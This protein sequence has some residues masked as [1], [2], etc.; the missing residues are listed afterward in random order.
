MNLSVDNA[1]CPSRE[2]VDEVLHLIDDSSSC[3]SL[4][5][6]F[7]STLSTASL[8]EQEDEIL[9][10]GGEDNYGDC[11]WEAT[12]EVAKNTSP[13]PPCR[14]PT[15]YSETTTPKTS[16]RRFSRAAISNSML[17]MPT[18]GSGSAFSKKNRRR[19]QS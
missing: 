6:S 13:V 16:R 7:A 2:F 15:P 12:A 18:D 14:Y 8:D 9:S 10:L 11:R 4:E 3:C 1:I 19:P 17:Q 5:D